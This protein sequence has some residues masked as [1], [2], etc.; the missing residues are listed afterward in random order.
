[1]ITP[2]WWHTQNREDKSYFCGGYV[3]YRLCSAM[4]CSQSDN[5]HGLLRLPAHWQ[6][7]A[8]SLKLQ[9]T[10][11]QMVSVVTGCQGLQ[12]KRFTLSSVKE[13][14][15]YKS[16]VGNTVTNIHVLPNSRGVLT[17]HFPL[18]QSSVLVSDLC[19][20]LIQDLMLEILPVWVCA[21]VEW[22]ISRFLKPNTHT[23]AKNT[24]R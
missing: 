6:K 1:M 14:S 5:T 15:V 9:S 21:A 24:C 13:N 22:F 16:T 20:S 8:L 3:R 18:G 11:R 10:R 12:W 2:W 23:M 7:Q 17:L 19:W 4:Y